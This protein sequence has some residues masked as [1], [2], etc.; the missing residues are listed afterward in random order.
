MRHALRQALSRADGP[1]FGT[2]SVLSSLSGIVCRT[3]SQA[4]L[5]VGCECSIAIGV[6]TV[7][8]RRCATAVRAALRCA[9]AIRR[10]G[11]ACEGTAVL[12]GTVPVAEAARG[13]TH[14]CR[15]SRS[16]T[17]RLGTAHSGAE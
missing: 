14:A 17:R 13:S 15:C 5:A 6:A 2:H 16:G 1:D 10:P 7:A 11:H 8:D 4:A 3:R 9:I 12:R